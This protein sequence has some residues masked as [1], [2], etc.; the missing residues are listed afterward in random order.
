METGVDAHPGETMLTMYHMD[1]NHLMLTHYCMAKNQPRMRATE[2]LKEDD[3]HVL[4]VT[5]TFVDGTNMP[6]G[7]DTPHMDKA[8]YRFDDR[9]PDAFSSQWTFYQQG[10]EQWMEAIEY[11]RK[12]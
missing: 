10:K 5:F 9:T 7:R 1:V 3:G 6:A 12:Q 2:L 11:V 8:R 4:V